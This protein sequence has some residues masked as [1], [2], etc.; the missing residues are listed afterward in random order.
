MTYPVSK[1]IENDVR[2]DVVYIDIAVLGLE[3]IGIG[4]VGVAGDG[5]ERRAAFSSC[6]SF[7]PESPRGLR[8]FKRLRSMRSTLVA[9][10]FLELTSISLISF[11]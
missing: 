4:F 10:T 1:W 7:L 6:F 2:V 11:T 9:A 3:L 8:L 5:R